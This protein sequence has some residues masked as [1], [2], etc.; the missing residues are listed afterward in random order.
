MNFI[1]TQ[2]YHSPCGELLLGSFGEKLCL[3]DWVTEKHHPSVR[4]RLEQAL[5]A[6]F[7]DEPSEV[8]RR[9]ARELDEYFA[10]RL[11]SFTLP[12]LF[13]G[14]EFQKRVWNALLQVP[15]GETRSY[16]WQA[17]AIGSPKAVRAVGTANGANSISIFAPC[18]RI[19]GSNRSL[20]GYGGGLPV[21]RFLLELEESARLFTGKQEEGTL[22][23][24]INSETDRL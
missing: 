24:E 7:A 8:T 9:A 5:Q 3:C 20:T 22:L 6:R 10:G 17:M 19:I 13:V 23:Q 4:H 1:Y 18:H 2:P 12:L 11:R 21:K 14:T 16:G 15:Y